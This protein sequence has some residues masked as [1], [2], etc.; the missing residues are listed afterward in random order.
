MGAGQGKKLEQALVYSPGP[1]FDLQKLMSA[2]TSITDQRSNYE[3]RLY[4]RDHILHM[5]VVRQ[6]IFCS[7]KSRFRKC[8]VLADSEQTHSKYD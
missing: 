6:T 1:V 5:Q 7:I 2:S 3:P 8:S 4:S